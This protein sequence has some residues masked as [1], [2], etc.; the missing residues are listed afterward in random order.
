[1]LVEGIVRSWKQAR[2]SLIAELEQ[3][4]A[5]E[6]DFRPSTETRSV[7]EIIHHVLA[8]Q[9]IF[10]AEICQSGHDINRQVLFGQLKKYGEEIAHVTDKEG[11]ISR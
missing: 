5:E 2:E 1:M 9:R 4:P 11:L 7:A 6:F 10:V 8:G 3:I